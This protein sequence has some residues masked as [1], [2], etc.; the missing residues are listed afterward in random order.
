MSYRIEFDN[1]WKSLSRENLSRGIVRM[2]TDIHSM[3]VTN[4]PKKS[5]ALAN[6]GRMTVV[7]AL[8]VKVTFGSAR[9]DYAEL[10]ERENHLHPNTVRYLKRAG[11]AAKRKADSYF[12]EI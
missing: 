7:N 4:A 3:A 9:V 8:H 5:H 1:A 2:A 6:S 10:R 11:D 12:K